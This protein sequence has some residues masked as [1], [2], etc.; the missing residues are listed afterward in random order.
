MLYLLFFFLFT[1]FLLPLFESWPV[2]VLH[3]TGINVLFVVVLT[4]SSMEEARFHLYEEQQGCGHAASH[5][6]ASP[7]WQ[8]LRRFLNVLVAIGG[9]LLARVIVDKPKKK[10]RSDLQPSTSEHWPCRAACLCN[11]HLVNFPL[12]KKRELFKRKIKKRQY[13]E[14]DRANFLLGSN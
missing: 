9:A 4:S 7:G 10:I 5:A 8:A 6:G 13:R 2:F 1:I 14:Y 12:V 3:Y 11:L